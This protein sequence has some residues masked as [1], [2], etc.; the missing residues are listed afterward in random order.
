MFKLS[1]FPIKKFLDGISSEIDLK[2]LLRISSLSVLARNPW[3]TEKSW[4][5]GRLP[6]EF[7]TNVSETT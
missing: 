1:P 4:K 7:I 2:S 5:S 6:T 3:A